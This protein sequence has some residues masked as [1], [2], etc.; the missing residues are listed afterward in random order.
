M[1]NYTYIDR[2][3]LKFMVRAQKLM[4]LAMLTEGGLTPAT[5]A[6][7]RALLDE[8]QLLKIETELG[9]LGPAD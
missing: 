5:V 2:M 9:R 8:E 3:S 1:A 4:L 7:V 6:R